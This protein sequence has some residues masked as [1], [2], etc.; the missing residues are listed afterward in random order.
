MTRL[1]FARLMVDATTPHSTAMLFDSLVPSYHPYLLS[2]ASRCGITPPQW[3][4][5]TPA[6]AQIGYAIMVLAASGILRIGY[7]IRSD[8]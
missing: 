6:Y 8:P 7:D 4:G 2:A 1:R 5:R 3:S